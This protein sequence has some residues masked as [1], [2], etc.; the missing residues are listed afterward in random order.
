MPKSSTTASVV[1]IFAFPGLPRSALAAISAGRTESAK[2]WVHCRNLHLAARKDKTAWPNRAALQKA[3][4]GQFALHSQ[5][6]QMVCH[7]FLANV[8]TTAENRRQGRHEMKYPWRD[9]R[10]YPLLW[11]AQ[12]VAVQG[13]SIVLPMGRDRPSIVLPLPDGFV[14]GGCKLVWNGSANELHVTVGAQ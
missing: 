10:Y 1:R 5:S 13:K 8:E 14:P 6:A 2:V 3:V 7:A 9:K 4:K 12:A 11:P